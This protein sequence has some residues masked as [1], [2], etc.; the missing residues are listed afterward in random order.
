MAERRHAQVGEKDDMHGSTVTAGP[1]IA[2]RELQDEGRR[3]GE[4]MGVDGGQRAQDRETTPTSPLNAS[5]S[6]FP[7]LLSLP[8]EI[9]DWIIDLLP[10]YPPSHL[11]SVCLTSRSLLKRARH[12]LYEDSTV[13]LNTQDKLEP[14]WVVVDPVL[15]ANADAILRYPHLGSAVRSLDFS[16][17]RRIDDDEFEDEDEDADLNAWR[18]FLFP[19]GPARLR[20]LLGKDGWLRN[21]YVVGALS[22][23]SVD[24]STYLADV[25]AATRKLRRLDVSDEISLLRSQPFPSITLAH[26]TDLSLPLQPLDFS[27]FPVLTSLTVEPSLLDDHALSS[28]DF[29]APFPPTLVRVSASDFPAPVHGQLDPFLDLLFSQLHLTLTSLDI[30]VYS[31]RPLTHPCTPNLSFPSVAT[32]AVDLDD[33]IHEPSIGDALPL[34]SLFPSIS[35]LTV[36]TLSVPWP[37]R[38]EDQPWHAAG[39]LLLA[40]L[41][42]TL[43]D[44]SLPIRAFPPSTLLPFLADAASPRLRVLKITRAWDGGQRASWERDKVAWSES[45]WARLEKRCAEK[46]VK[47]VLEER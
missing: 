29:P 17:S 14:E 23:K 13:F 46:G 36:L 6:S 47:L 38:K 28:S 35:S 44:I 24:P 11:A 32:L 1:C 30:G 2:L 7:S 42:D 18:A 19:R 43:V 20:A 21:K 25:L 37:K 22:S 5:P 9:L 34:A 39:S 40:Q 8:P 4:E 10:H 27:L 12:H 16:I 15:S 31:R 33:V 26:L 41:P 3:S 45:D